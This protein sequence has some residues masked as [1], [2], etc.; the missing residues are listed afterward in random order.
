[1][2][3]SYFALSC[4]PSKEMMS[5]LARHVMQVIRL[6]WDAPIASPVVESSGCSERRSEKSAVRPDR[7]RW[8]RHLWLWDQRLISRDS[9]DSRSCTCC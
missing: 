8:I 7:S 3:D 4:F 6:V 1:M 9:R 2:T 5:L